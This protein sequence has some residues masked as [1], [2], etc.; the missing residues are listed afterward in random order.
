[1]ARST[2]RRALFAALISI[3]ILHLILRAPAHDPIYLLFNLLRNNTKYMMMRS[4]IQ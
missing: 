4:R 3:D 1:M 2:R